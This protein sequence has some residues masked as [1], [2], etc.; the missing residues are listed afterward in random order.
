[1]I[2]ESLKLNIET[3]LKFVCKERFNIP[4]FLELNAEHGVVEDIHLVPEDDQKEEFENKFVQEIRKLG[5]HL[6]DEKQRVFSTRYSIDEEGTRI[7]FQ[8]DEN[9]SEQELFIQGIQ[10]KPQ[11]SQFGGGAYN[12]GRTF[13]SLIGV[14]EEM[15]NKHTFLVNHLTDLPTVRLSAILNPEQ[16]KSLKLPNLTVNS[17]AGECRTSLIF[18]L[19]NQ[20]YYFTKKKATTDGESSYTPILKE[21]QSLILQQI[22]DYNVLHDFCFKQFEARDH[23]F[24]LLPKDVIDKG[25]DDESIWDTIK[26]TRII[27]FNL[28]EAARFIHQVPLEK[29]TPFPERKRSAKI[30]AQTLHRIGVEVLVITDEDKGAYVSI[31][32][33][34]G[35]MWKHFP[36]VSSIQ[37]WIDEVYL[38]SEYKGKETI[39]K[40]KMDFV[41]C[42]DSFGATVAF[43]S[44]YLG[45]KEW[46][47]IFTFAHMIAGIVSRCQNANIGDLDP[48]AMGDVFLKALMD[49]NSEGWLYV[50][51]DKDLSNPFEG[52]EKL[53]SLHNI[54]YNLH[55][56]II[57]LIGIPGVGRRVITNALKENIRSQ[58]NNFV[59]EI[60][61]KYNV[62]LNTVSPIHKEKFSRELVAVMENMGHFIGGRIDKDSEEDLYFTDEFIFKTRDKSTLDIVWAHDIRQAIN[63]WFDLMAIKQVTNVHIINLDATRVTIRRRLEQRG[64]SSEVIA[65]LLKSTKAQ[66]YRAEI[67]RFSNGFTLDTNQRTEEV[68]FHLLERVLSTMEHYD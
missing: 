39:L 18:H 13:D 5:M 52:I 59:K 49:R 43:C 35:F 6:T 61:N 63:L 37:K 45:L 26:H 12:L 17:I 55:H 53:H 40:G 56:E 8:R 54:Q 32:T 1:M 48:E 66:T 50:S 38:N 7:F 46:N 25:Y 28:Y 65:E 33:E 47:F 20:R 60:A 3:E 19:K 16:A 58:K 21:R 41:G 14:I 68:I 27:S 34:T 10:L 64:H 22:A 24:W 9:S 11:P 31:K 57:I 4:S 67:A 23:L 2:D 29:N 42:G 30:A 51:D 36:I 62:Q 15:K 44:Q